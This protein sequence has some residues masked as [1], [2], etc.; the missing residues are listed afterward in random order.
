M[1]V[2]LCVFGVFVCLPGCLR[3][4]GRVWVI[5]RMCGVVLFVCLVG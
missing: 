5:V 4:R 2:C 3:Y 1:S